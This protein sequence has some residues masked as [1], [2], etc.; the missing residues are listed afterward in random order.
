MLTQFLSF[1][2]D[3]VKLL[4]DMLDDLDCKFEFP[5]PWVLKFMQCLVAEGSMFMQCFSVLRGENSFLDKTID[6]AFKSILASRGTAIGIGYGTVSDRLIGANSLYQ[7]AKTTRGERKILVIASLYGFPVDS[8]N[9]DRNIKVISDWNGSGVSLW[10]EP[11][12][13]PICPR[14]GVIQFRKPI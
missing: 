12:C 4:K 8:L 14:H 2:W 5:V 3:L 9:R 6:L 11:L 10:I 1:R 13:V 7:R